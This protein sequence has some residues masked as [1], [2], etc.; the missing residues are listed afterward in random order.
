MTFL[1]AAVQLTST[2][3]SARSMADAE[4]AID[5]AAA[6]GAKFVALPEVFLCVVRETP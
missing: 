1:A 3:D 6:R 5:E 4:A 2:R